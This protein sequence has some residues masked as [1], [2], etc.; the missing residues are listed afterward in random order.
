[1]EGLGGMGEGHTT[2]HK[3]EGSRTP[4]DDPEMGPWS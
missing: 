2:L 3:R 1:M 4:S